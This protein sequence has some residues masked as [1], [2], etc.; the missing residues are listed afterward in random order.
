MLP[1]IGRRTV[2]QTIGVAGA[3]GLAS[4]AAEVE[5]ETE[6]TAEA[7][8]LNRHD[9]LRTGRFEVE[10]DGE[11]VS[12]WQTV[13]IPSRSTEQDE[14]REGNDADYEKKVWGQTTFDDLEM[15]RGLQ[16][17]DVNRLYDWHEAVRAGKAD[18]GRKEIAVKLLDGRGGNPEPLLEWRFEEAWI[19]EYSPPEL[20][21]S[22]DGDV[23]TESITVA[24]DRMV[25]E[26]I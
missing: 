4:G 10:L 14:Y 18:E 24:F 13:T 1:T 15:E 11:A 21:A 19:K 8:A 2:L 22:A 20:D 3:L 16:R 23:A 7:A 9:A 26:E 12:G 17:E 25:R 5:T 6:A